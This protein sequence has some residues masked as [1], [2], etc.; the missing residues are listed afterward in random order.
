MESYA[1]NGPQLFLY[2]LSTESLKGYPS[3][4]LQFTENGRG[5]YRLSLYPEPYSFFSLI[6]ERTSPTTHRLCDIITEENGSQST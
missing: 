5:L 4:P 1:P 3:L 2:S 6:Y